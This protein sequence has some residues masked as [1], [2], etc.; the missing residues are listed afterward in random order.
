M[1]GKKLT[2]VSFSSRLKVLAEKYGLKQKD[3]AELCGVSTAAVNKWFKGTAKLKTEY[4][5][6]LAGRFNVSPEYLIG[7]DN[8]NRPMEVPREHNQ[9]SFKQMYLEQKARADHLE[10]ELKKIT[11]IIEKLKGTS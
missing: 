3:V 5:L 8:H 4:A 10:R 6:I 11:A 9:Q 7:I 1:Q 2:S